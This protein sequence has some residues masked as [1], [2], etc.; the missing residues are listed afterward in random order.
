MTL[1]LLGLETASLT[2]DRLGMNP[3][4]RNS[5]EQAV[6]LPHGMILLTGPTGS[7]KSTTLYA[8]IRH[9]LEGELRNIM[10]VEDPV[11]F[12][13]EGV[14]QTEVDT[15]SDKVSFLKSLRS[16]LR[17]D[18]DVIMIGEIR[19]RE[20]ADIAVRAALTGHLVLSTLHTN[21]ALGAVTRL[22]DLG[23]DHFLLASVL[24]LVAA[25]RLVRRLCRHCRT[26]RPLKAVE[27]ELL[28]CPREAGRTVYDAAGCLH[29]AGTGYT[30]RMGVFEVIPM[31][32][33]LAERIGAGA[34]ESM[35]ADLMRETSKQGHAPLRE[36]A[37]DKL[38]RGDISVR[39]AIAATME[40]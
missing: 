13:I 1:R 32:R 35:E 29:C 5:F 14:T 11:E 8:A 21:S 22:L 33:T 26:P 18:P 36:D 10:T 24:R 19:D 3:A 28:G 7:G 39:D 38:W 27:A 4:Q 37:W 23:L 25:Q 2:L 34:P 20:T 16:I 31:G 30:G 12:D 17:H 40:F 9:I 6:R 15:R